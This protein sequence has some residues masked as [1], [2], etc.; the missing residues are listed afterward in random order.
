MNVIIFGII[1]LVFGSSLSVFVG[2]SLLS[3]MHLFGYRS[4]YHFGVWTLMDALVVDLFVISGAVTMVVWPLVSSSFIYSLK[5]GNSLKI[6]PYWLPQWLSN[7]SK[8]IALTLHHTPLFSSRGRSFFSWK[9]LQVMASKSSFISFAVFTF[10]VMPTCAFVTVLRE[11]RLGQF[12]QIPLTCQD[13]F[14]DETEWEAPRGGENNSHNE[15]I[16]ES[17]CWEYADLLSFTAFWCAGLGALLALV[18]T[19]TA[20]IQ[21]GQ[22]SKDKNFN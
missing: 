5:H 11:Q 16:F 14:R 18:S 1:M 21:Y 17:L 2:V 12:D 15:P 22:I 8:D 10:I 7:G 20:A 6:D 13:M 9:S 19:L 4:M 3:I